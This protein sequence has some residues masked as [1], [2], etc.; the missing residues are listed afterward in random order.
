MSSKS[1]LGIDNYVKGRMAVPDS[2]IKYASGFMFCV[3]I[4]WGSVEERFLLRLSLPL[5]RY[6][7]RYTHL[8]R[9]V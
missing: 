6:I 9:I 7:F 2:S 8:K 5:S 4:A 3:V 1:S